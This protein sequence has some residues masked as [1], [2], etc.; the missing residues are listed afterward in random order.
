MRWV[1]GSV[2]LIVAFV[3]TA[4]SSPKTTLS[5]VFPFFLWSIVCLYMGEVDR[6]GMLL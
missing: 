2:L 6:S 3:V 4:P 5:T 1:A